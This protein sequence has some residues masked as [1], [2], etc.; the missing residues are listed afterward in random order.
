VNKDGKNAYLL[1][2]KYD[3]TI[4][5]KRYFEVSTGKL[6]ATVNDK[7]IEIKDIDEFIVDG[8]R[9]PREQIRIEDGKM[10]DTLTFTKIM[11]NAPLDDRIFELPSLRFGK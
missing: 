8:I 9:F 4:H 2:F 3:K 10:K 1:H 7:G 6:L 5:Y 11:I